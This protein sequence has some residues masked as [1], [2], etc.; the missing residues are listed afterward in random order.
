MTENNKQTT[1]TVEVIDTLPERI[2]TATDEVIEKANEVI[3][4]NPD[5]EWRDHYE[6]LD[7]IEYDGSITEI[8]NSSVPI[9]HNEIR[10]TWY[11]Y[12]KELETAYKNAGIGDN[13][14][15]ND[16]MLAIFLHI[17]NQ[18]REKFEVWYNENH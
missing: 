13:P 15:E 7:A 14:K 17:E 10:D 5:K 12:G 1:R 18:V 2:Q 9:C 16:G 4:E 6:L 11:L 3:K 8:V